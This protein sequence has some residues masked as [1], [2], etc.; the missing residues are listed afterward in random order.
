MVNVSVE[1][2]PAKL[3][4]RRSSLKNENALKTL[5]TMIGMFRANAPAPDSI[6]CNPS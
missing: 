6:H 5:S 2:I 4:A 1:L 3:S